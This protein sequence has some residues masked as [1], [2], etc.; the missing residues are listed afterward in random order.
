MEIAE[1]NTLVLISAR[2]SGSTEPV[3]P[4]AWHASNWKETEEKTQGTARSSIKQKRRETIL[5]SPS[6]HVARV[7]SVRIA[8]GS[9]TINGNELKASSVMKVGPKAVGAAS[10][11]Y[12]MQRCK[13]RA[14]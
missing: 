7:V 6:M 10:N 12:N 2:I 14:L 13:K 8:L 1:E 9:A 4:G 5:I 3:H 11:A